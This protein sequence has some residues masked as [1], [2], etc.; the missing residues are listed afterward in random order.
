MKMREIKKLGGI[1]AMAISIPV[2]SLAGDANLEQAIKLNDEGVKLIEA[3]DYKAAIKK[4]QEALEVSPKCTSAAKNVGKMMIMG[5]RFKEAK[6]VLSR[7]LNAVPDDAGCM[8]QMIQACAFLGETQEC[9]KWIE[10]LA[11]VGDAPTVRS[12]PVL[13]LDQGAL[14]EAAVAS[15]VSVEKD[16]KDPVR[17]FNRGLVADAIP[18]VEIAE[19]SY[20]KAIELNASYVEAL[21]NLGNLLERSGRKEDMFRAYEKAYSINAC[22]LTE[23]NLGRKLVQEKKDVSRGLDLLYAASQKDDESAEA[24]TKMLTLMINQ[25]KKNNKGGVK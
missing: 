8:I 12:L 9:F 3:K 19:Q 20:R 4:F 16:G 22:A 7:T 6:V 14:K 15:E 17:W 13:L 2:M 5:Q 23:Y 11:E 1:V 24:A 10:K 18:N 21:V 25:L